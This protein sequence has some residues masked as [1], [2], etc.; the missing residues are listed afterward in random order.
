MAGNIGGWTGLSGL[1]VGAGSGYS[2]GTPVYNLS[3]L[4]VPVVALTVVA[5]KS[6]ETTY[7]FPGLTTDDTVI[8]NCSALSDGVS[9]T[10]YCAAANTVT[11]RYSNVSASN[12]AQTAQTVRVTRMQFV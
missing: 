1:S 8:P 3:S 5:T 11:L 6:T 7:A 12:A 2:C 10:A 9:L 4:T